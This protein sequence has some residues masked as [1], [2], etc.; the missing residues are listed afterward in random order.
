MATAAWHFVGETLRDGH[1]VPPDG[2][3]LEHDAA[4]AICGAGLHASERILDALKYAP[5]D[6]IC[7]VT[8]EGVVARHEDKLVCRR[9]TVDWRLA[10]EEVLRD[11]ARRVALEVATLWDMP[12]PVRRFLETGGDN[13]R[14]AARAAAREASR[15]AAARGDVAAAA[16][17]EAARAAAARTHAAR[18]TALAAAWAA[19]K[20]AGDEGRWQRH[21]D[22]LEQMVE[23]ARQG[24]G[25][26]LDEW[27]GLDDDF[28]VED[29]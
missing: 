5:G 25:Q 8:C 21:S 9:R 2:V 27:A 19:T 16:A 4:V 7:R 29:A 14:I 15:A 24:A 26:E 18:A 12:D 22:L 10:G 6:M 1:A 20:A 17:G 3:P 23:E 28:A 13:H 11:F